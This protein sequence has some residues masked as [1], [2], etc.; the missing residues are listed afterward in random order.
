VC[1]TAGFGITGLTEVL[2]YNAE[3]P[4]LNT[5]TLISQVFSFT[6][7]EP[8]CEDGN[9]YCAGSQ[10]F[11]P[12]EVTHPYYE[13]PRN[14]GEWPIFANICV[15]SNDAALNSQTWVSAKYLTRDLV[16]L[17]IVG[18]SVFSRRVNCEEYQETEGNQLYYPYT[19]TA[20][21]RAHPR[22]PP[23][24]HYKQFYTR[25]QNNDTNFDGGRFRFLNSR[26]Q[27]LQ[28]DSNGILFDIIQAGGTNQGLTLLSDICSGGISGNS[29]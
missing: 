9:P 15:N 1:E 22:I 23:N 4:F 3:V 17:S 14:D 16:S 25:C 20:K 6:N 10:L 11:S 13:T 5:A 18:N 12:A 19:L 8:R 29:F 26:Y 2:L 27:L 24:L 7:P 28:S 21:F